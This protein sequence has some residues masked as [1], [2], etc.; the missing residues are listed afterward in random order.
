MIK[1]N[2]HIRYTAIV[3]TTAALIGCGDNDKNGVDFI[4]QIIISPPVETQVGDGVYVVEESEYSF[5]A[6][7]AAQN[8]ISDL[9]TWTVTEGHDISDTGV[10]TVNDIDKTENIVV[11]AS[12]SGMQDTQAVTAVSTVDVESFTVERK[13]EFADEFVALEGSNIYFQTNLVT[14]YGD[15]TLSESPVTWSIDETAEG[16]GFYINPEGVLSSPDIATTQEVTV[17]AYLGLQP[18]NFVVTVVST[19][20]LTGLTMSPSSGEDYLFES[21]IK[22]YI[23][24]ANTNYGWISIPTDS[25]NLSWD[26]TSNDINGFFSFDKGVLTIP[27]L[28]IDGGSGGTVKIE[29]YLGEYS[30][31]AFFKVDGAFMCGTGLNDKSIPDNFNKCIKVYEGEGDVLFTHPITETT[32]KYLGLTQSMQNEPGTYAELRTSN[33]YPLVNLV[34]FHGGDPGKDDVGQAELYCQL[35]SDSNFLGKNDWTR[36]SLSNFENLLS[37]DSAKDTKWVDNYSDGIGVWTSTTFGD[38]G[39]VTDPDRLRIF[40]VESDG[41]TELIASY[42]T[43]PV[44]CISRSG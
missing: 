30:A 8:D 43:K 21:G 17:T 28:S 12:Y 22:T 5:V 16:A 36:P 14:N 20:D 26:I 35:L 38:E 15:I 13:G 11:T 37:I 1:L 9:V 40:S 24:N 19:V 44:S 33:K 3:A 6:T 27:N 41:Y 39:G 25:E 10:L 31:E 7:D 29:A 2:K 4:S 32:A 18:D 42:F 23:V 34:L